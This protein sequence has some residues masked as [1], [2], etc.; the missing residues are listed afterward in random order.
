[1]L[2]EQ[3]AKAAAGITVTARLLLGGE[4]ITTP[5]YAAKSA[6]FTSD[7]GSVT[8]EAEF[9]F[10]DRALFDAVEWSADGEVFRTVKTAYDGPRGTYTAHLDVDVRE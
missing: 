5:G 3:F 8:A 6:A 2:A 1:M 9:T 10:H 7:G 4:E